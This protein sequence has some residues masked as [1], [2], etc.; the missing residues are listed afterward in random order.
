MN[1]LSNAFKHTPD[2]GK[3]SLQLSKL[4]KQELPPLPAHFSDNLY[5]NAN[6]YLQILVE[7]NGSGVNPGDL[8]KIFDPFFQSSKTE[9]GTGI[10]LSLSKGIVELHHGCIWAENVPDGGTRFTILVPAGN[11]H[12]SREEIITDYHDSEDVARYKNLNVKEETLESDPSPTKRSDHTIL[13][14]EDNDE[15]RRY[16]K[17][18]LRP[19]YRVIEAANGKEGKMQAIATM[20]TLILSDIMMPVMD[21]LQMCRDLKKDLRTSHIPVI[22]L[23]ARAFV[24]QM[25]EGL[26]FGADDYITKPFN[27]ALLLLK[28]KNIIASRENLKNLYAKRLSLENMGV[29]INSS[30]EKFLQKL[31]EVVERNITDP[32]LDIER[33]CEEIGMSRAS[34]YR[35]LMATTNMSPSRY[36]QSVRLHLAAKMLRETDMSISDISDTVGFNS[37]IHFSA[38]FRKQYGVSPSK[39]ENRDKSS[40]SIDSPGTPSNPIE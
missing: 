31:N 32:T 4:G 26:E 13:I 12:F 34:L 10:G 36:I 15:L 40:K 20:P 22:L 2:R 33:F 27:I 39:F 37:L 38:T 24:L 14:V 18:C 5:R 21:G 9:G 7:D 6:E 8:A 30:D 17:S 25:K 19:Y 35:K 16:M 23:T 11:E 3:I 29:E 1:L 28:M